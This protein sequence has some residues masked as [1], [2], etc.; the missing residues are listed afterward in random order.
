VV[1]EGV[2]K[3]GC[4]LCDKKYASKIDLKYHLKKIHGKLIQFECSLCDE[5]Y[6]QRKHL[7][8]HIKEVHQTPELTAAAVAA[9]S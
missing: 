9:I 6:D 1:H 3:Y 5:K 7:M 8:A 4:D 2:K